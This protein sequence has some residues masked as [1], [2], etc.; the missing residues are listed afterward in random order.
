[1]KTHEEFYEQNLHCGADEWVTSKFW[2]AIKKV[3]LI[4][5]KNETETAAAH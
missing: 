1:M 4:L 2:L 5:K 3:T